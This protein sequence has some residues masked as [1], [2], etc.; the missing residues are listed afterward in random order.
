MTSKKKGGV[1]AII[2]VALFLF[3]GLVCIEGAI[4]FN[5][6]EYTVKVTRVESVGSDIIAT[7]DGYYSSKNKYLIFCEKSDGEVIVFENTD[8]WL[9]GKFNSLD[10][11]AKIHEGQTYTFVVVGYRIPFLDM[12]QNIIKIKE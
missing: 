10:F 12:Y 7:E 8:E 6:Q 4:T 11:Y 1:L 3:I 9:R 5:D 2:I